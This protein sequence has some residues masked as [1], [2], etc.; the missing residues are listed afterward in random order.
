MKPRRFAARATPAQAAR[1]A[2]WAQY[3]AT[4]QWLDR[5]ARYLE[6]GDANTCCPGCD[7]AV[8]SADDVHHLRYP[9]HPGDEADTDLIVLCRSCHTTVH[10]SLDASSAWRR[11]TRSDATWA[12]L[13]RLRARAGL[14]PLRLDRVDQPASDPTHEGGAA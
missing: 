2:Q 3:L 6:S 14:P 4:G 5:R 9:P 8:G 7:R 1:R 12:I 10:V 13:A 11:M